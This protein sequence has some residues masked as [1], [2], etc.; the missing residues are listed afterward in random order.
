MTI[1][2]RREH[3]DFEQC[4]QAIWKEQVDEYAYCFEFLDGDII[5]SNGLEA[6]QNFLREL[7]ED[8]QYDIETDDTYGFMIY[9]EIAA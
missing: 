2:T 3:I 8:S 1:R 9:R 5:L 7:P 6:F 4:L